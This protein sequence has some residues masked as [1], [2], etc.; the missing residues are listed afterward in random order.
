LYHPTSHHLYLEVFLIHHKPVALQVR[1]IQKHHYHKDDHSALLEASKAG[2]VEMDFD[3]R[4]YLV[5]YLI[6]HSFQDVQKD[7]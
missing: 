3:I 1:L 5:N 2:R 4:V 7:H 6:V